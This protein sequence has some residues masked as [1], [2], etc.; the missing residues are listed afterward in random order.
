MK[1]RHLVELE[2]LAWWPRIF[3]DG[4][5]DFLVVA[6]RTTKFYSAFASRLAGALKRSQSTQVI[7]LCSGAG[8]PW[9]DLLPALRNEGIEVSVCLTDKYPNTTALEA[10]SRQMPEVRFEPAQVSAT[11]VPSQ[12]LGFRTLFTSFHHFAPAEAREILAAAVRDRQGIAIFESTARNP[13][14]LAMMLF[15]PITVWLLTPRVRPFRWSSLLWTYVLPVLPA[16]V[17]LDGLTSCLRTYTASEMLSLAHEAGGG[18]F[19]WEAGTQRPPG[20]PFSV[21]YL[22]GIPHKSPATQ[23]AVTADE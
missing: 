22:I 20:C 21:P 7:D 5:T 4:V 3:R 12:L 13:V 15:V 8:G 17:L 14:A 2:D 10:V 18:A 19:T 11:E 16:A 23:V 9:P 6:Q 1:R